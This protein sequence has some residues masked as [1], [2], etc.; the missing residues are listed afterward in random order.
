MIAPYEAVKVPSPLGYHSRS[1][2]G[3]SSNATAKSIHGVPTEFY[4]HH[5]SAEVS[6]Q[7]STM[8]KNN[9]TVWDL[10][11][12]QVPDGHEPRPRL[13]FDTND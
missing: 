1:T 10:S 8:D 4:H 3:S 5:L 11:K 2:R 6:A 13:F 7:H 9:N 12:M